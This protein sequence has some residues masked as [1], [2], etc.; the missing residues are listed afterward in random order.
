MIRRPAAWILIST[1][2]LALALAAA[3]APA[4]ETGAR[5]SD[6][7]QIETNL[8][9]ERK[10]LALDLAAYREARAVEART[11]TQ[12]GEVTGRLD[13]ALAGESV[14]LGNLEALHLEVSSARAAAEI[15]ADRVEWQVLRIEDRLRRIGF[16]EGETG[17]PSTPR[18]PISGRWRV[19]VRPQNQPGTFELALNGTLVTG[20]YRMNTGAS[21]SF[22][23]T[24][25]NNRLRMERVDSVRGFDSV[26]QGSLD[27]ATGQLGGSWT[28]NELAIGQ[29]TQGDWTA[30]REGAPE[31]QP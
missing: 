7:A 4:Q 5:P 10:L 22:R 9:L 27:A 2:L 25:V 17:R 13:Q 11:R 28:A 15:A 12:V 29:P 16:L 24:Y 1:A 30:V 19:I 3:L 31:R 14:A 18:D 8:R 26:Y 6:V 21:G 20:T 23:G